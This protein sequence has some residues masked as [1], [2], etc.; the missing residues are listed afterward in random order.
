MRSFTTALAL[1]TLLSFFAPGTAPAQFSNEAATVQQ[2]YRHYF[3]R[4]PNPSEMRHWIGH[5]RR[6][7][8][9]EEVQFNFLA[10]DEYF[11]RYRRDPARFVTGLYQDVLNRQPAAIDV[12]SWLN[13]FAQV[14]WDRHRLVR[15][16]Q[17]AALLELQQQQQPFGPIGFPGPLPR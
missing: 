6:G 9:Q 11:N 3:G 1:S 16:F 15:E 2:L 5:L 13:R 17:Q 8:P 4:D 10:N 12:R 14:R 7:M